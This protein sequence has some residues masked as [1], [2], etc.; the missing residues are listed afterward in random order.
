MTILKSYIGQPVSRVDGQ[1]KVK[2]EAKYA[3]EFNVPGLLY[4]V[5]I[6]SPITKG[7]IVKVN[8]DAA[9][10]VEGVLQVFTHENRPD[11]AWFDFKYKDQIAPP[12]SPFRPL[13]NNEIK[14]N[15]QPVALVVAETFEL[16]RYAAK[17][18]H[19]TYEV[20]P[21]ETNLKQKGLYLLG[22]LAGTLLM[23][24]GSN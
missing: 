17:L 19:I 11:L 13:Y 15:G 21:H 1:L 9:L 8:A 18:V 22:I 20:E 2:G 23:T 16:A 14:Y 4:G 3:A 24:L 7:K 6:S 10:S 5:V 12:G